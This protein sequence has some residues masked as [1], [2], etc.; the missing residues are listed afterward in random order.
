MTEIY[1]IRHAEAEGN[2]YRR[3]Q[4]WYDSLI[5]PRGYEQIKALSKRFDGVKIDR[6]YSSPLFRTRTTAS[7][8][9]APRN[10]AM[11]LMEDMREI[12]VGPWEDMP[13]GEIAR[14]WP[15]QLYD[16]N[17]Q[18]DKFHMEGAETVYGVQRRMLG[19]IHTVAE[20]CPGM[21]VAAFSHGMAIR[22]LLGAAMGIP[23]SE[24]GSAVA[25]GDN[26]AVSMLKVEGEKISVVFANDASHISGEISTLAKQGWWSGQ[27]E[28]SLRFAPIDIYENEKCYLDCRS[29]GWLSSHG[30]ME[31]YSGE[32]F[33]AQAEEN[34]DNY[35]EAIIGAYDKDRFAGLIQLDTETEKEIGVGRMPFVYMNPEYRKK[36]AGIQ[37]IG[38]AISRFRRMGRSYIRLRC[39]K[40]NGIAQRFYERDGFYKIG[41]DESAD[42]ALDIL[43]K[44]IARE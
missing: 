13:W 31:H 32:K 37:L 7:A 6:V 30:T 9:C 44:K 23:M 18:I 8:I 14:L 39:A 42:V 15:E 41:V 34:S 11:T 36:G 2:L 16:F 35:P 3:A 38:E 28:V 24:I 10:L 27:R 22:L 26:T 20:E 25:H 43:E 1:I 4:G 29:E 5:T 33:L 17:C 40:E 19:A 12:D 21:T